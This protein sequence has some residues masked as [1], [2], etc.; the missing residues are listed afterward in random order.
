[1]AVFWLWLLFKHLIGKEK[2]KENGG[3]F[4]KK[5]YAC[6]IA[7]LLDYPVQNFSPL[8]FIT[9]LW[10]GGGLVLKEFNKDFSSKKLNNLY[11][12]GESLNLH[13][14]VVLIFQH[15]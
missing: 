1:M 12:I 14:L 4:A 9:S 3:Y 8:I 11:V 2:A 6:L 15:W 10:R 13:L 7:K 5:D